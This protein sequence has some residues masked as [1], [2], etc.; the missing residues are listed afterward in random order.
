MEMIS[1][2]NGF[3]LNWILSALGAN[4]PKMLFTF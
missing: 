2:D 1:K 3:K 4:E